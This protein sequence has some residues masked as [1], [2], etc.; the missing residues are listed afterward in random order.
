MKLKTLPKSWLV[1]KVNGSVDEVYLKITNK[2]YASG[3]WQVGYYLDGL[4]WKE[5]WNDDLK[6]AK[7]E[8]LGELNKLY[9]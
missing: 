6:I 7:S 1:K 9:E 4:A 5:V 3:K 8:L 2:P